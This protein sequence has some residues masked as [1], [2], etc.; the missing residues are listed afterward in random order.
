MTST[1]AQTQRDGWLCDLYG[2][3]SS[4]GTRSL[5]NDSVQSQLVSV[6]EAVLSG[7]SSPKDAAAKTA[8]LIMSQVDV[9]TPWCNL[10][11]MYLDAAQT[12]GD[13]KELR[14]LVDY[15]VELAK[16]PDAVNE[17]PGTKTLDIGGGQIRR[18]EPGQT[19]AFEEGI[20]WSDLP[21]FSWNVTERFQGPESYLA[22]L[23]SPASPEAAKTAWKNI[24]TYLALLASNP[25]AQSIPRLAG[26]ARLGLMALSIA[27]EHSPD[28]RLGQN[29]ELH[30]PAAAQWF[31][32][33]RDELETLCIKGTERFYP[34]D[35]WAGG[36]V[37][38]RARLQFWMT[39]MVE[40]G[41]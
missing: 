9:G 37:C 8:L 27:L 30:A 12:F 31:R 6:L 13:D 16:L 28:T 34:G 10:V 39:R 36:D 4:D 14:A 29:A 32:I 2:I 24:N 11:G 21:T 41:Y 38:D 15:F 26:K 20:L 33:A 5:P 17:G 7:T 25:A 1:W 18:I 3:D 22:N 19:V 40:L 23:R 35:L